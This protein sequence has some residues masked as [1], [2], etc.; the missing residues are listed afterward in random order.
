MVYK[1]ALA[2]FTLQLQ[3]DQVVQ[4]YSCIL[5]GDLRHFDW[6]CDADPPYRTEYFLLSMAFGIEQALV[7]GA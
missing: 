5:F 1:V 3:R 6:S 7:L 4:T 2:P